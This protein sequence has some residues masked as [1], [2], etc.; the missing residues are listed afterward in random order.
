MD[1][2]FKVAD[3]ITVM[4]NGRMLASGDPASIRASPEVQVAYLGEG[5]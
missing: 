3:I 1:A 5:L 4:V 2:V